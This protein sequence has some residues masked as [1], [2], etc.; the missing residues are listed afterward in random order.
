[1]TPYAA[2]SLYAGSKTNAEIAAAIQAR[3]PCGICGKKHADVFWHE[4]YCTS[5]L[6]D[7]RYCPNPARMHQGKP[8]S[9]CERHG[10]KD[11]SAESGDASGG[12]VGHRAD[13]VVKE[14]QRHSE[15]P[16]IFRQSAVAL[17]PGGEVVPNVW[18]RAAFVEASAELAH[19]L[20]QP[21]SLASKP[22]REVR[23]EGD[24]WFFPAETDTKEAEHRCDWLAGRAWCTCRGFLSHQHCRHAKKVTAIKT[25]EINER[26]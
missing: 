12:K 15:T 23:R 20:G 16:S 2:D 17:T 26:D 5:R 19:E 18:K 9:F 4:G 1:V 21:E 25:K 24:S 10:L 7:G 13:L 8:T 22:I 14:S 11:R 3:E 6:E